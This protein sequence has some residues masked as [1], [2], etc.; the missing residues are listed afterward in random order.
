MKEKIA[1]PR[2]VIG[3]KYIKERQTGAWKAQINGLED[4]KYSV[5]VYWDTYYL[6]ASR[7]DY[8]Y[9]IFEDEREAQEL[10]DILTF[11][12]MKKLLDK[13]DSDEKI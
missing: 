9:K 4:G 7:D 13:G 5:E 2:E 3:S 1:E 6:E 8:Y 12:N 11:N 10:Y